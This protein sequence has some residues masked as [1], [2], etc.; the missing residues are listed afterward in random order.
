MKKI[1]LVLAC[2]AFGVVVFAGADTFSTASVN[3]F[4]A[5]KISSNVTGAESYTYVAVPFEEFATGDEN[6]VSPANKRL[7]DGVIL[8]GLC[9]NTSTLSIYSLPGYAGLWSGYTAYSFMKKGVSVDA[10]T[11]A[12]VQQASG[13][14]TAVD[15]PEPSETYLD[16]GSG[17]FWNP[18]ASALE[19]NSTYVPPYAIYTYGQVPKN[20]T[21][22]VSF[23]LGKTLVCPPGLNALKAIDLNDLE[24]SEVTTT[25]VT[26]SSSGN[27]RRIN[28]TGD[29]I[30]FKHPVSGATTQLYY[31]TLKD[32]TTKKWC[33]VVSTQ[34]VNL[35]AAVIPAGTAFWYI[36][37]GTA[38]V[39]WP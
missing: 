18:G 19:E 31:T 4:G 23:S 22:K 20:Y 1:S 39:V 16:V 3:S 33:T 14:G 6:E 26:F 32:G 24:W 10:W 8:P 5:I 30:Q 38:S 37:Q 21:K 11:P 2:A 9:R 36:S 13:E 35:K 12:Q 28:S 25:S 15:S 34:Q 27:V 17:V 7:I 29:M